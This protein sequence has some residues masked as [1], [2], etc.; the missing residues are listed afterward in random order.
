M[1]TILILMKIVSLLPPSWKLTKMLMPILSKAN[2]PLIKK[3]ALTIA[4]IGW[5]IIV[6]AQGTAKFSIYNRNKEIGTLQATKAQNGELEIIHIDSKSKVKLLLN[7]L[8]EMK[9]IDSLLNKVLIHSSFQNSVNGVTNHSKLLTKHGK[10][11]QIV[12]K[13]SKPI[14]IPAEKLNCS[15]SLLLLKEPDESTW[16]YLP[17]FSTTAKI[18]KESC[19]KYKLQLPNG[20]TNTY[21][22]QNGICVFAELNNSSETV[23]LIKK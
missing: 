16:V 4:L 8:I 23:I 20:K 6:Q 22:Y 3:I 12:S 10:F 5:L 14:I 18:E 7:I 13:G 21:K 1:L 15:S 2:F 11:Y 19:S 17:V 9:Q